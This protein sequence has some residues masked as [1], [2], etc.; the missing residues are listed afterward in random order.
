MLKI[1]YDW[2]ADAARI[3]L[4]RAVPAGGGSWTVCVDPQEIGGMAYLDLDHE[5]R[6][7]GL[8]ILDA[9]ELLR[10]DVILAGMHGLR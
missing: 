6:I 8:E 4:A 10:P 7:V 3:Y 2:E 5:G 1:E 9:G